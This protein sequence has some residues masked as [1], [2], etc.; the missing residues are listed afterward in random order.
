MDD[1]FWPFD[2]STVTEWAGTVR[3]GGVVHMGTDFGIP[4]GT[5]L[6]ATISGRIVRINNDG[7][8]AYV[9]DIIRADGLCVRNAHLSRMDV[10]TGDQVVAGQVIGLTGGGR[11]TAGAGYSTGP[12]LHWELRWDRLWQRGA[13]VDPRTVTVSNFIKDSNFAEFTSEPV[14]PIRRSKM[15][16]ILAGT[17]HYLIGPSFCAIAPDVEAGRVWA[18]LYGPEVPIYNADDL[19]RALW[20]LG[21]PSNV[22]PKLANEFAGKWGVWD[23]QRGFYIGSDGTAGEG[24]TVSASTVD[25]LSSINVNTDAL[26]SAIA[27]KLGAPQSEPITKADIQAAIEANYKESK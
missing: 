3:A 5:P 9:L 15:R 23:Y 25:A 27:K 1:L 19:N 14:K 8:G 18:E 6:R 2:L 13:W 12:H 10:N 11:G 4:Q 22:Q 16:L 24:S 21:I 17:N 26:A 7:L 20:G